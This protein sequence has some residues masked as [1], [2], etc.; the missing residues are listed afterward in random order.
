MH[1]LPYDINSKIA[2]VHA[3][4]DMIV[5]Y[6]LQNTLAGHLSPALDDVKTVLDAIT[7]TSGMIK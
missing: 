1:P 6:E 2:A 5:G 7:D 4:H 3:Y